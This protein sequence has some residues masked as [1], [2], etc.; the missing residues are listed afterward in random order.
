MFATVTAAVLWLSSAQAHPHVFVETVTTFVINGG[1][2]T[3]IR[4]HWT[5]DDFFSATLL[6]TFDK[7]GNAVFEPAEAK[8]LEQG[9]FLGSASGYVHVKVDGKEVKGLK[10]RG[11][12]P[13]VAD[14]RVAY[15]FTLPL[16]RPID[17]RATRLTVTAFESSYYVDLSPSKD[18]PVRM[19]GGGLEGCRG[20][21]EDDASE[22]IYF[23]AVSPPM[24]R[25]QC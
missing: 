24:A 4:L 12:S 6:G 17:P 14:G 16:A 8:D 25:L 5:F 13:S 15:D 18:N 23:G 7:N 9:A 10:P 20:L 19:E 1:K 3:E 22:S 21:V 2:V 11:F